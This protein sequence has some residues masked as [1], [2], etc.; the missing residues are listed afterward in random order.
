MTETGDA[1]TGYATGTECQGWGFPLVRGKAAA[2][3]VRKIPI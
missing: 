2:L 1:T 3:E